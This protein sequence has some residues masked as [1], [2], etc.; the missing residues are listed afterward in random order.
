M[1]VYS[2]YL[3]VIVVFYGGYFHACDSKEL[4]PL[5]EDTLAPIT[6]LS[7]NCYLIWNG[8]WE[9]SRIDLG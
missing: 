5:A 1:V 6:D 4:L 9:V 3:G 2:G 7:L 8:N